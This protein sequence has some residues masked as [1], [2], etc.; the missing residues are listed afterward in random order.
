MHRLPAPCRR[1]GI[2]HELVEALPSSTTSATRRGSCRRTSNS[3]NCAARAA[4]LQTTIAALRIVEQFEQRYSIFRLISRLK[5]AK[6]YQALRDYSRR[7]IS[8]TGEYLLDVRRPEANSSDWSMKL[9]TTPRTWD[10]PRS[11]ASDVN[12]LCEEVPFSRRSTE[13]LPRSIGRTRE[14]GFQ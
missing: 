3:T 14:A 10:M 12:L 11:R 2:E 9:L 1:A 13:K 5:F 7:R 4:A 8:A 6:D